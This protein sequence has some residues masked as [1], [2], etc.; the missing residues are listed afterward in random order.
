MADKPKKQKP[1]AKK[2]EPGVLGSLSTARP[3]R[4]GSRRTTGDAARATAA[5]PVPGAPTARTRAKQSATPA[6]KRAATATAKS[7]AAR[8]AAGN[9]AVKPKAAAPRTFEATPAAEAAAEPT[10]AAKPKPRRAAK[11]KA[12]A[13]RTFEATPAAEAAAQEHPSAPRPRAVRDAAPGI[14]GRREAETPAPGRPGGRE[15]TVTAVK[16]AGEVAQLGLTIGGKLL[17]RAAERLP[18]P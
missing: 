8:T 11:P 1:K 10:T 6:A 7:A 17:K 13:P 14:G 2:D 9:K 16:A 18:K 5:M 15:L 12:A 4:I 3:E